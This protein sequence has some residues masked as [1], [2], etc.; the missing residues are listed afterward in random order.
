MI[1]SYYI[2]TNRG[3]LRPSEIRKGEK[4][5]GSSWTRVEEKKVRRKKRIFRI[6]TNEGSYIE[7]YGQH[8]ILTDKGWKYIQ[9]LNIDEKVFININPG[10]FSRKY[11]KVYLREIK[12][13]P[14]NEINVSKFDSFDLDK[15]FANILGRFSNSG[16]CDKTNKRVEWVYIGNDL[17][18]SL[19]LDFCEKHGYKYK[20]ISKKKDNKVWT[21]VRI[22]SSQLSLLLKDLDLADSK[23]RIIPYIIFKCPKRTV[24]AF[25]S[26]VFSTSIRLI[27]NVV[28][29]NCLVSYSLLLLQ[30]VKIL[31]ARYKI[32]SKIKKRGPVLYELRLCKVSIDNFIK[33]IDIDIPEDLKEYKIETNF[34]E[35]NEYEEV[36]QIK[37]IG[38]EN[39]NLIK[40]G[41]KDFIA[42]TMLIRVE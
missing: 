41:S 17:K 39:F 27:G 34:C 10:G 5:L 7:Y 1:Y 14:G 40:T 19:L 23:V 24:S 6:E 16:F 32:Y 31:L 35:F 22:N 42:N 18:I 33:H 2:P 12:E 26:G 15:E 28:E 3:M 21:T 37:E 36:S 38:K 25:L 20:I 30:Q 29:T 8:Q 11:P 13:V 4:I 9:D